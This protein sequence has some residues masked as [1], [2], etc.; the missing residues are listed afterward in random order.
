MSMYAD[1][2]LPDEVDADGGLFERAI[3]VYSQSK[4]KSV[5]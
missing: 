1:S 4:F 2:Q 5:Y 3:M